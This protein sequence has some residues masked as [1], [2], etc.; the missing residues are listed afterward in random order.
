M[1]GSIVGGRHGCRMQ[2]WKKQWHGWHG[3]PKLP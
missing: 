3:R 1:G 2:R